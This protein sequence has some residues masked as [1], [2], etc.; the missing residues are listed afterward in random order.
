MDEVYCDNCDKELKDG[1]TAIAVTNGKI[2]Q[3]VEG[4][5]PDDFPSEYIC[6]SYECLAIMIGKSYED[7][8][9]AGL[10]PTK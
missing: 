7:A 6:C 2:S 10:T 9:D 5:K 4:F 3:E 1:A 8:I